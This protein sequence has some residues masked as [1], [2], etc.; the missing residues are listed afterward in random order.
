MQASVLTCSQSAGLMTIDTHWNI[1]EHRFSM[2]ARGLME[3]LLAKQI[4]VY[5]ANLMAK[6]VILQKFMIVAIVSNAVA[7]ILHAC[8]DEMRRLVA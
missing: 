4:Y 5:N 8:H 1:V 7:Y 2:I 3:T 6:L